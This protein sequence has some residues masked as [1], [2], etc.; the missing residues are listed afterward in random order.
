MKELDK[1]SPKLAE[2]VCTGS[3]FPE[4]TI[5]LTRDHQGR[6]VTYFIATLKNVQVV[7]HAVGGF[8]A[9]EEVPVEDFSLNF[10]EIKVTYVVWDASDDGE[11]P[12]GE[13]SY[14]CSKETRGPR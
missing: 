3:V 9:G 14:E 13:V 2:S 10:E 12:P 1:A 11:E 8:V 6:Q 7:S 5:H 4:V